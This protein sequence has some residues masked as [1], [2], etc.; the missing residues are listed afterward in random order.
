MDNYELLEN[1]IKTLETR[2]DKQEDK[3]DKMTRLEYCVETLSNTVESF[4]DRIDK[5]NEQIASI[6]TQEQIRENKRLEHENSKQYEWIK[7]IICAVVGIIIS[8]IT[9]KLGIK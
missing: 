3:T 4:S 7:Y 6:Q 5:F 2:M 9:M 1:R 8:Y